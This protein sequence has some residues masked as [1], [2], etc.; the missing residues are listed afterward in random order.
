MTLYS[1]PLVIKTRRLLLAAKVARIMLMS[2][3]VIVVFCA[4]LWTGIAILLNGQPTMGAAY[5]AAE[6]LG[7][8]FLVAGLDITLTTLARRTQRT[9]REALAD[10]YPATS[11]WG[12]TT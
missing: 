2:L 9:A 10:R 11:I 12:A 8:I 7:G 3:T 5:F 1:E 4:A 6:V